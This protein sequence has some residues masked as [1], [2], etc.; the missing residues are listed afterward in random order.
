MKGATPAARL[1]GL[2]FIAGVCAH[3]YALSPSEVFEKVAPSV[4]AV[5]GLD[6]SQK[7]FSYGSGVV[8]AP[9]KLI[10]NC[11]V[12]AKARSIQVYRA[13]S[14]RAA[15]LEHA[16]AE[17]D[18]CILAVAGLDSPPVAIV[19]LP[20]LK[21]GQ[22]VY[23]VGNP[24]KLD[25]T[26]SEGLISGLR[27]EIP[28]LPPIQTSAPISPGSSGGGLFDERGRLIGITTLM[29]LG[30]AR[31][32][33]NLNFA[34]PAE[35]IGEVPERAATQLAKLR[36]GQRGTPPRVLT[37]KTLPPV[38]SQWT[39]RHSGMGRT[40]R[41]FDVAVTGIEGSMVTERFQSGD[42]QATFST[43]ATAVA[44]TARSFAGLRIVELAPYVLCIEADP[45]KALHGAVAG[46]SA[47][48]TAG[49]Q[50]EV[51][52][53]RREEVSVP[54]GRFDAIR[55]EAAG[56]IPADQFVAPIERTGRAGRGREHDLRVKSF[57]YVV[58]YA[59]DTGR[60]V[61]AQHQTFD[62]YGKKLT[63]ESLQLIA[64]Q[65]GTDVATKP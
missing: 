7:P 39:Y 22:R 11:H 65:P 30:R 18:L 38:G 41:N 10:T 53:I 55:V 14:G 46:Y 34:T 54:A 3:A 31:I 47:D 20:E 36:E 56:E 40:E 57:R 35:W 44:F 28:V 25:L 26:L 58:W 21:I 37:A 1:F 24:E 60:Y 2:G 45:A 13:G 62:V 42:E 27:S 33:Q 8:F 19:R 49:W 32:A 48:T 51:K 64:F 15:K 17:R 50:V 5:R 23:A 61:Q 6:A 63:E 43:G 12:L 9:G 59:Q 29:V 52:G 16:D 4:W